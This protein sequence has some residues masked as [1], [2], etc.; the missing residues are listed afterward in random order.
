M[1]VLAAQ[2]DASAMARLGADTRC[3]FVRRVV[4]VVS[5]WRAVL[6]RE[7]R[8]CRWV[9]RRDRRRTEPR[10]R[11]RRARPGRRLARCNV[12][13]AAEIARV[14]KKVGG[15]QDEQPS[16]TLATEGGGPMTLMCRIRMYQLLG[17]GAYRRE[18]Q[19]STKSR[20]QL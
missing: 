10:G 18:A 8:L 7:P 9:G 4:L 17:S 11:R 19:I 15:R 2:H 6:Q 1:C 12:Y 20:L 14:K 16:I 3:R 5:S 13:D